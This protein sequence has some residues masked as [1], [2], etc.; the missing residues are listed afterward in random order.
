MEEC[1]KIENQQIGRYII[2]RN[3]GGRRRPTL[4]ILQGGICMKMG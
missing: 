4:H 1:V 2:A 3:G